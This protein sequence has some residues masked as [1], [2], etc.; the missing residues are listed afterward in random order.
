MAGL[1]TTSGCSSAVLEPI[2]AALMAEVPGLVSVVHSVEADVAAGTAAAADSDPAV[3]D[4]PLTASSTGVSHSDGFTAAKE[5]KRRGNTQKQKQQNKQKNGSRHGNKPQQQQRGARALSVASSTVLAGVPHL[6]ETLSGLQF[7]VSP[8][9]FFQTNTRQAELLYDEVVQAVQQFYTAAAVAATSSGTCSSSSSSSSSSA[10][11]QQLPARPSGTVLDLYCGTGTISLLLARRLAGSCRRVVGFDVSASAI[12]DARANAMR[13]GVSNVQFVCGDLTQLA[14]GELLASPGDGSS[15]SSSS[16]GGSDSQART[17]S[18]SKGNSSKG[19]G[20]SSSSSSP[21]SLVYPQ[22]Y[23]P[24]VIV[25]DPA[26]AGLSRS[27][28]E[29]LLQSGTQR[30]VYVSCNAA[31]QARDLQLLCGGLA[32]ASRGTAA[33]GGGGGG[34]SFRFVSWRGVDMFP[35]TDHLETVVVLDRC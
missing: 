24:D 35:Q 26:R 25:V 11:L 22:G 20:S 17:G 6:V 1:V 32:D 30:V 27:V 19:N 8:H 3:D 21:D 33:G 18:T 2:A 10:Q 23:Q 13:N 12:A 31:T 15:S 34:A 9:S 4:D 14:Q 5:Q 28:V 16:S 29:F 7:H